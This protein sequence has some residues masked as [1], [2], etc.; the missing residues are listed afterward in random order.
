MKKDL[1]NEAGVTVTLDI[2]IGPASTWLRHKF[3]SIDVVNATK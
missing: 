1:M 3:S 2:A